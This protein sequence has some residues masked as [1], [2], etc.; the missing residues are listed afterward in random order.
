MGMGTEAKADEFDRHGWFVGVGAGAG[1]DFISDFVLGISGGV[2]E[3]R[4]TGTFNLRGGYRVFSWLAFEGMYEGVYGFGTEVLGV[5]VSSQT[6][7]SLVVNAKF[8]VPTWRLQPYLLLGGGGQQGS[9][10][11][12]G[13]TF[14]PFDVSRWDPVVRVAIGL[15]VYVTK[16][17][18]IDLELAPSIRFTDFVIPTTATDNVTLTFSGGVQYRF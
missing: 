12:K 6:F 11:G 8:I 2:V 18:V 4:P 14:G 5:N 15:D 13:P 10:D 1:F 9:F 3:I 16:H 7:N 17:W